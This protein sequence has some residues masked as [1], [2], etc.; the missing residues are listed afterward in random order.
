MRITFDG[1]RESKSNVGAGGSPTDFISVTGIEFLRKP[2]QPTVKY[3]VSLRLSGEA[4]LNPHVAAPIYSN[5]LI[6][7]DLKVRT[8][9]DHSR[10]EWYTHRTYQVPSLSQSWSPLSLPPSAQTLNIS[11][12]VFTD[13]VHEHD[14]LHKKHTLYLSLN[15]KDLEFARW[16][17][18]S[19]ISDDLFINNSLLTFLILHR[20]WIQYSNQGSGDLKKISGGV[21]EATV[22]AQTFREWGEPMEV[23]G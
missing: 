20:K 11:I 13:Q 14:S 18:L 17:R 12:K 4:V 16:I 1:K 22:R 9:P 21:K 23:K 3:I 15:R 2:F 8:L 6:S 19:T 10:Q 5:I 7:E